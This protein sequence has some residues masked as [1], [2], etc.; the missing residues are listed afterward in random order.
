M[1]R[2]IV[3]LL[4]LAA[5]LSGALALGSCKQKEGKPCTNLADCDKGLICCFDGVGADE[6]L[7]VCRTE[8][9]CQPLDSGVSGDASVTPDATP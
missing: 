3:L 8:A 6:A 7:G 5:L 9:A 1:K 4:W 2:T